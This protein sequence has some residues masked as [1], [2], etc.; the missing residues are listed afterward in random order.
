MV[1]CDG[2]KE[3]RKF[4]IQMR[5]YESS[6]YLRFLDSPRRT[7]LRCQPIYHPR[8]ML[9]AILY[10]KLQA[11]FGKS[12]VGLWVCISFS[13]VKHCIIIGNKM[14]NSRFSGNEYPC[15]FDSKA[16]AYFT[17]IKVMIFYL[18]VSTQIF[19][20]MAIGFAAFSCHNAISRNNMLKKTTTNKQTNKITNFLLT[21][22]R[23]EFSMRFCCE[24]S[25]M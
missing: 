11:G 8:I 3:S 18:L 23:T 25:M 10:N 17:S 1:E 12:E 2:E 9:D 7:F 20:C 24:F 19:L 22:S 21:V 6:K 13:T 15:I 14:I 5:S 16:N 4:D